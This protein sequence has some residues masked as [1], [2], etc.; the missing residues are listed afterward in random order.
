MLALSGF[1]RWPPFARYVGT[2]PAAAGFFSA[3][4]LTITWTLDNR[5]E[6]EGKGT[7]IALMNLIGQLAPLLGTRIYSDSDAPY[8]VK[9]MS[10]CT[11]FMLTV[12]ALAWTLRIILRRE[13][14][15]MS[16]ENIAY[17]RIAL[18]DSENALNLE[19]GTPRK[20]RFK[21]TNIL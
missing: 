9:G 3:V 17:E 19:F 7:G 1:F 6:M 16:Q 14:E 13:N 18:D 12:G 4:A 21:S 5:S 11:V 20:K 8:Y 15:K 2:F 10:I